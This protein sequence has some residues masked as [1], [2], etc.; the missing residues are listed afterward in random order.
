MVFFD[1]KVALCK[2]LCD[3]NIDAFPPEEEERSVSLYDFDESEVAQLKNRYIKA[4][5]EKIKISDG[6]LI[7]NY[8]KKGITGYVGAN[9]LMEMAFAFALEKPIFVLKEPGSQ[10]WKE[11]FLG[12]ET[13]VINGNLAKIRV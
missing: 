9:T 12:M 11:E 2:D 6:V 8:S 1:R 13:I 5:L 7:A 10:P 4:H 3:L